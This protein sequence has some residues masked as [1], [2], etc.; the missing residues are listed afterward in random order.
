MKPGYTGF[1][2]NVIGVV[3]NYEGTNY[4]CMTYLLRGLKKTRI[5]TMMDQTVSGSSNLSIIVADE[6]W[7]LTGTALYYIYFLIGISIFIPLITTYT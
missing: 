1:E 7:I 2:Q 5:S 3:T 4:K 6:P